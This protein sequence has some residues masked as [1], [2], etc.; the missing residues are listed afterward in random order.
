MVFTYAG[1]GMCTLRLVFEADD[2]GRL[3]YTCVDASNNETAGSANWSLEFAG[4]AG[5]APADQDAFYE[6]FGDKRLVSTRDPQ[7]SFYYLD[8]LTRTRFLENEFGVTYEGTYTYVNTGANAADLVLEYDDDD[9]CDI[10]VTFESPTSGQS[11]WDC[12]YDG[13]DTTGWQ[14]IDRP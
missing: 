10:D 11:E 5:L 12:M 8:F 1:G 2:S 14:A 7:G 4:P 13:T 3:E 9:R 6:R